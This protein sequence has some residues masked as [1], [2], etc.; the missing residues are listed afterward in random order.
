[1]QVLVTNV[2]LFSLSVLFVPLYG[3]A[4]DKFI[5]Q[6]VAVQERIYTPVESRDIEITSSRS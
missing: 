2:E 6:C 4:A 5:S 1:M 3:S